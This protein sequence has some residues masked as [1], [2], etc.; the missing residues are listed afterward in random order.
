MTIAEREELSGQGGTEAL[1]PFLGQVEVADA[2]DYLARLP[3]A[4]VPLFLFSPPYNLGRRNP[5]SG[6][7]PGI[8]R[9]RRRTR[10]EE[11]GARRWGKW[12][13]GLAYDTY[14]DNLPWPVY[15]AWQR[16][17]LWRAWQALTEDGVIYYVHKPR[18]M[19][20][21]IRL[22]T[23]YNPDLPLRQ[24]IIW[25]RGSGVNAAPTHCMPV[26][27]WILV[28][29]KPGFRLR[30]KRASAVG[31]VW[32][33]PPEINTPHPAPFPLELALRVLHI[34]GAPIVCDPFMG[35]GTTGRAARMLGVKLLGCDISP[36]YVAQALQAIAACTAKVPRPRQ[37]TVGPMFAEEDAEEGGDL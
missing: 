11:T 6:R 16:R 37:P 7:P 4:S 28:F 22:P 21:E 3:R 18:P 33:I 35:S 12:Q 20:G 24:I 8:S 9:S 32:R 2:E 13:N 31:D 17:V 15:T 23:L 29:A 14:D 34:T 19:E 26:H 30:S 10:Q 25:D 1:A 27:E 36:V 5:R